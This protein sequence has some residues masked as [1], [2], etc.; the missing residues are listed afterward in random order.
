MSPPRLL[1][2]NFFIVSAL[3]NWALLGLLHLAEG[4]V[5]T[6]IISGMLPS[7]NQSALIGLSYAL[8]W[9]SAVLLAPVLFLGGCLLKAQ[10][11][12][13]LRGL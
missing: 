2:P 11:P 9:F 10:I 7:S 3:L 5:H 4:R 12:A 1:L 6:A 13:R 8:V